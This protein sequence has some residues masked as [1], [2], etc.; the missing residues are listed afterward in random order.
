M[1]KLKSIVREVHEGSLA[2]ADRFIGGV[3]DSMETRNAKKL[4]AGGFE[5][6]K[7]ND[8]T[9]IAADVTE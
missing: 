8:R 6:V 5:Q 9:V 1:K 7:S 4:L 2:E 3:I